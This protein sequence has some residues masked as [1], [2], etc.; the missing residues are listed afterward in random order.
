MLSGM[1]EK[2]SD[3]ARSWKEGRRLRAWEL[4]QAGWTQAA[5]AKALGVT[6]GAVSQWLTKARQEGVSALH[7]R[8]A[9]G[10]PPR[11][12]AEQRAQLPELLRRGSE[13]YGFR[14]DLWTRERVA[15]VVQREFGV[16]YSLQQIGRLLRACGWTVQKPV[17]RAKQRNDEAIQHWQDE[18]WPELKKRP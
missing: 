7:S 12:T 4:N 2:L 14:G 13:A 16:S 1:T 3:A 17:K 6:A 18:R 10:P 9:A 11:L 15:A 8:K 5:I